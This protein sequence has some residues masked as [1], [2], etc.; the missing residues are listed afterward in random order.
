MELLTASHR[1]AAAPPDRVD[2][3]HARRQR[4][5]LA[6]IDATF[7][8]IVEGHAPPTAE[9]VAARAGISL[10]SLFRYFETLTEMQLEAFNRFAE[11]YLH[12]ITDPA[13]PD[14]DPA[15]TPTAAL[16]A[17]AISFAERRVA[18]FADT[19]PIVALAE[20]RSIDTPIIARRLIG[21]RRQ[22]ADQ[23][24]RWFAPE[25]DAMPSPD[26][27]ASVALVDSI[28]SVAGY[29]LFIEVHG[30]G[31]DRIAAAWSEAIA[32]VIAATGHD[33]VGGRP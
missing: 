25:L 26:A 14:V 33:V 6:A 11:R 22:L 23:T 13:P 5:R 32:A 7:D 10:S 19:A 17:R 3:R 15:V 30:L 21:L 2:G 20:R 1:P 28:A 31:R 16:A 12:L 27:T 29:R 8:L 4:G 24:R 18:L 9:Q